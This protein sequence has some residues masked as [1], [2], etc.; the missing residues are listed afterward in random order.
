MFHVII[1]LSWFMGVV[2]LRI[3][4][5]VNFKQIKN[6]EIKE[7]KDLENLTSKLEVKPVITIL[8]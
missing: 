7:S 4:L 5:N 1:L 2:L 8:K 6:I 3:F